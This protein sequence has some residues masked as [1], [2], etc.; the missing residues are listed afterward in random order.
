MSRV[1]GGQTTW[2]ANGETWASTDPTAGPLSGASW[3][4]PALGTDMEQRLLDDPGIE[5]SAISWPSALGAVAMLLELQAPSGSTTAPA[6]TQ[7]S[8]AVSMSTT[9][10]I[11]SSAIAAATA[12]R[13]LV[14]FHLQTS[15]TPPSTPAGWTAGPVIANVFSAFLLSTFYKVAVGGETTVTVTMTGSPYAWL[16]VFEVTGV[17]P[18]T[19]V[20]AV[21]SIS[22]EAASVTKI[23][24]PTVPAIVRPSLAFAVA[25]LD[26]LSG[27]Y[28]FTNG[29]SGAAGYSA[30]D[31]VGIGVKTATLRGQVVG[32][33]ASGGLRLV[34]EALNPTAASDSVWGTALWGSGTWSSS[35]GGWV[36]ISSRVRQVDW[37]T[38]QNAP[39]TKAVVGVATIT[40][41]NLDGAASPWATSGA[42]VG[43]GTS[44]SWLRTGC[45]VRFGVVA[46]T[47]LAAGLPA[48]NTYS[49]FFTGK[50]EN[51]TE[52]TDADQTDAWVVLTLTET[53]VD[54]GSTTP[55]DQKVSNGRALSATVFESMVGA[56]WS[57]QTALT[58]PGEDTLV[59]DTTLQ[60]NTSAG[61]I[62]LLTDGLHWDWLADGRGRLIIVKRHLSDTDSGIFFVNAPTSPF[63]PAYTG[64]PAVAITTYSMVDRLLNQAN[65][66]RVGGGPVIAEDTRSM[67]R[68]STI[69]NGYGFPRNDLILQT[70]AEVATLG[71]RVI[72]LRAW[73]D[74][75]IATV[76]LD[77]DQDSVNLPAALTY[78]A[79]RAREMI[80]FTV[81]YTHPSGS[82]LTEAVVIDGQ[83][84]TITPVGAPGTQLKW[85]ATLSTGHAG[86]TFES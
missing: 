46:T 16:G 51:T 33:R 57:Y 45:L 32:P 74:L 40:L 19:P 6:I 50:L 24:T 41:E 86:N 53:T 54:F 80:T 43:N 22:D 38:G 21:T 2:G 8:T 55:N 59:P 49:A 17:D 42:F 73:D 4:A 23:I 5:L 30:S 10:S 44:T 69:V 13:E 62:D 3:A 15:A 31:I 20:G 64:L 18:V 56:G 71:Q 34:V 37:N 60:G 79:C 61:R 78:V 81:V 7:R 66:A 67:A 27:P 25:G 76:T 9:G 14:A 35:V 52:E 75:G 39:N 48:L 70:D 85:T 82:V 68:F 36:D 47:S 28:A 26:G 63:G 83:H 12:G 72:A 1:I 29:Y 65:G 58:V 84:H 77:L 11:T